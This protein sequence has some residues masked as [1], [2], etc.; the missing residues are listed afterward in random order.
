MGR[1]TLNKYARSMED[2]GYVFTKDEHGNRAY[3]DHDIVAFRVLVDLLGR[4]ADYESAINATVREYSRVSS[5]DP[6]LLVAMPNSS[7]EIATL[8]AKLDELAQA[9][10][11]LSGKID[12]IIDE[13]VRS[14][15]A[16]AAAGIGDQFNEVLG[17]VRA[18]QDRTDQKVDELLSRVEVHGKRKRF[19]GL[20]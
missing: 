14:E 9:M 8:H 12:Q 7:V 3:T 16:A 5:S 17:E 6:R 15:V 20:F 10:V 2:A 13:R 4:R 18:A 1:S 19:F 11:M